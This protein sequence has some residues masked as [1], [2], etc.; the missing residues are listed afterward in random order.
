MFVIWRPAVAAATLALLALPG[1]HGAAS[2]AEQWNFYMHQ[3][4]PNFATSRGAK[5]FTEQV[6]KATNGELKIR[7]HLAGTLQINASNITQAVGEDVVQIG[8]DLF[9][10][11]NIAVAGIPR[12]P[13]LIQSYEDF[14]KADAVL[15]PYIEKAFAQKGSTVL[16]SYTYPLQFVWG[17]KKL[18]SLDDI[19]GMKLRVA[20]P[21]QG[22]LVR[23]FGGVS[24]TMSA[25][26]VPSALDRGVVDGIF[27]AGVGAVLWKDLLKFGYVLIVNV[28]NSYFIANTDA[29]RKLSPQLQAE[30]RKAAEDAARW[31]QD[32]MK[33]EEADSVQ[34]LKSAGYTFTQAK[35]DEVM[36]AVDAMRP[37]WDEWAKARGPE[38]IEALGK[39]RAAL[40]R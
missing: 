32:T 23:R 9:N 5:L 40:G 26:E 39:V 35:S 19:K 13:M 34:L 16:A 22:E 14:A 17:R 18:A 31:N 4:A 8:D 37:Y 11:G 7:L 21:E 6:E 12:L 2:A 15:K 28:N 20:Q 38:I 33:T 27:T 36:R 25:P 1:W 3:S 29:Y 24:I 10:S 30:L